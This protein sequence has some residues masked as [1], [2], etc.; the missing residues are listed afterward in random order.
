MGHKQF[1]IFSSTVMQNS[2]EQPARHGELAG[3]DP[4]AKEGRCYIRFW[5]KMGAHEGG[6][7]HYDADGEHSVVEYGASSPQL[8][9]VLPKVMVNTSISEIT[10]EG[11]AMLLLPCRMQT[12]G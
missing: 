10:S 2:F 12:F 9:A 6:W 1:V 3:D 8:L 4:V 11:G 7:Q 5:R